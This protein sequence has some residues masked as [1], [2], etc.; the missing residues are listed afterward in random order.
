MSKYSGIL[1]S[2]G[3][4]FQTHE[5][6]FQLFP[7]HWLRSS[8]PVPGAPLS[9][10]RLLVGARSSTPTSPHSLHCFVSH[11]SFAHTCAHIHAAGWKHWLGDTVVPLTAPASCSVSIVTVGDQRPGSPH[12]PGLRNELTHSCS[13]HVGPPLG[14]GTEA[15]PSEAPTSPHIAASLICGV[16]DPIFVWD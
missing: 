8:S 7:Q 16:K 1:R 9:P 6:W 13:G 5:F 15:A 2:W 10:S 4:G 14:Q 12:P 11:A 3:L